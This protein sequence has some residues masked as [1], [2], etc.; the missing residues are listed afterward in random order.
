[1][2][3]FVYQTV[4]AAGLAQAISTL[5]RKLQQI[6]QHPPGDVQSSTMENGHASAI[7]VLA[8]AFI[9]SVAGW[10]ESASG[11]R[12]PKPKRGHAKILDRLGF[13]LTDTEVAERHLGEVFSQRDVL[14]HAHLWKARVRVGPRVG[15]KFASAPKLDPAY[16]DPKFRAA[17]D[18]RTRRSRALDLN[19]FPTRIWRRDAYVALATV[20]EAAHALGNTHSLHVSTL[21]FYM[22]EKGRLRGFTPFQM[23]AHLRHLVHQ[24]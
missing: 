11:R 15:V 7:V 3:T 19:L 4:T 10:A 21:H 8:A 9:E 24:L 1:M 5:L 22:V 18:P 16:G 2:S 17:L 12:I 20:L 13:L 23:A 14:M 6:P